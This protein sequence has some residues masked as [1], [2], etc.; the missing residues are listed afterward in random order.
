MTKHLNC[1]YGHWWFYTL[2]EGSIVTPNYMGTSDPDFNNFMGKNKSK[3]AKNVLVLT[4]VWWYY[5][6]SQLISNTL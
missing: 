3:W 1:I 4:P 5:K 2:L 6:F